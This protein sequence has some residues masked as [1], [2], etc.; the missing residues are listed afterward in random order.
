MHR[1]DGDTSKCKNCGGEIVFS[2]HLWKHTKTGGKDKYGRD[3]RAAWPVITPMTTDDLQRM[4]PG[5]RI[6]IYSA[7]VDQMWELTEDEIRPHPND[8]GAIYIY[9]EN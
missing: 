3:C 4:Y 5:K 1:K 7:S 9:I 6:A 8:D 2:K